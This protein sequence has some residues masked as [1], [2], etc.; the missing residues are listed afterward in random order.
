MLADMCNCA[1][2]PFL[3]PVKPKH[4]KLADYQ[5]TLLILRTSITKQYV[6]ISC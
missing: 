1:W 4:G 5:H 2:V 3:G 6:E